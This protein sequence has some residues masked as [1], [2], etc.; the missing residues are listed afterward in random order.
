L[1]V[2]QQEKVKF[3]PSLPKEYVEAIKD[4]GNGVA[5][6]MFVSFEKPFW[7]ENQKWLNFVTK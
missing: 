5:N 7:K 4:M 1:G 6:K 2:L 3:N